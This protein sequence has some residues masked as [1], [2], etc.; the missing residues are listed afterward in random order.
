M[1]R[2][3]TDEERLRDQLVD[4]IKQGNAHANF[5]QVTQN[6][7]LS[8][9]GTKPFSLPYSIWMLVEHIRV[10]QNDILNF[11]RNPNYK[12]PNWPDD[13][14]PKED[15][16]VDIEQWKKSLKRYKHDRDAFIALIKNPDNN[17]YKPFPYGNGQ[18][19]LREA[20]LIAD[21]TSYHTGEIIVLRRLLNDWE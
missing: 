1:K 17:L 21:H 6:I 2:E 14:W 9:M 12:S 18:N 13:F 3:K 16:P 10:T 19:L 5:E 4:V 20:L 15:S 11:S 7:S 8:T